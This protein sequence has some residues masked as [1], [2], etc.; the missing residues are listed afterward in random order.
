MWHS[1]IQNCCC[2]TLSFTTSRMNSWTLSLHWSCLC[3]RC[4]HLY[5]WSA[6]MR[7]CPPINAFAV[8]LDL[9]VMAQDKTP[10]RGCRWPIV[11]NPYRLCLTRCQGIKL[12]PIKS[13]LSRSLNVIGSCTYYFLIPIHSTYGP[14]FAPFP[15]YSAIMVENRKLP[16]PLGYLTLLWKCYCQNSLTLHS[17]VYDD[18][19]GWWN[20]E[21]V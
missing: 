8:P 10:K 13:R 21:Q 7:Q 15:R 16:T 5:V 1:F 18:P 11:D 20:R 6:P 19:A 17:I 9:V 2:I 3:W 14:I 4:C 12:D